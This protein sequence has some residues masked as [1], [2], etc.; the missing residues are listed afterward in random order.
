VV[1]L[2]D[3]DRPVLL[4]GGERSRD[5]RGVVRVIRRA[6]AVGRAPL[7]GR[8]LNQC[9][10]HDHTFATFVTLVQMGGWG[11]AR[12]QNPIGWS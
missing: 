7:R 11:S 12:D 3:S 4:D 8:P 10:S 9:F 1:V 2:P 6:G 5:H